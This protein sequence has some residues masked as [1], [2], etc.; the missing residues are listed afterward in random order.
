MHTTGLAVFYRSQAIGILQG[1]PVAHEAVRHLHIPTIC[2]MQRGLHIKARR[3]DIADRYIFWGAYR[4]RIDLEIIHIERVVGRGCRCQSDML[5]R[6]RI[7]RQRH[8]EVLKLH[9]ALYLHRFDRFKGGP[10]LR[11]IH[12]AHRNLRRI[13][14]GAIRYPCICRPV[15]CHLTL[16]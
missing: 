12:H 15:K 8:G 10:F 4:W 1:I 14:I 9:A 2:A 7:A 6:T 5:S 11:V 3:G 13:V 16:A